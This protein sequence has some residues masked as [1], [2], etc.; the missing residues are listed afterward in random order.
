M[1]L[2]AKKA[3][4]KAKR[5]ESEEFG[6][7]VESEEGR[8]N[9]FK[10]A[11]RMVRNNKENIG[12]RCLKDDDGKIISGEENLKKRWKEYMEKLV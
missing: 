7:M 12:G 2:E 4:A 10:I 5:E 11:K 3:V 1:I 9:L 6:R 8:Q